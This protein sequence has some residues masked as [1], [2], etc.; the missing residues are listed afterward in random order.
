MEIGF[1][2]HSF[3]SDMEIVENLVMDDLVVVG[4]ELCIAEHLVVSNE[5]VGVVSLECV[6]GDLH[7]AADARFVATSVDSL[8]ANVDEGL[9]MKHNVQFVLKCEHSDWVVDIY[10]ILMF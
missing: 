9:L 4:Y 6:D 7:V 3:G 10:L 1:H 2:D 5:I 8:V